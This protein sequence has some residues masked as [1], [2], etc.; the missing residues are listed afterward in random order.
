MDTRAMRDT[1]VDAR[2]VVDAIRASTRTADGTVEEVDW[3]GLGIVSDYLGQSLILLEAPS[4]EV[5]SEAAPQAAPSDDESWA[6][7]V[8][9]AVGLAG[10]QK[11]RPTSTGIDIFV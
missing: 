9:G 2:R 1:L 3:N 11:W 8:S 7:L 6:D 10:Q 4:P 5:T